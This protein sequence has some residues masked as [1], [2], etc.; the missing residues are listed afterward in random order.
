MEMDIK[1]ITQQLEELVTEREN[2]DKKIKLL[3]EEKENLENYDSYENEDEFIKK[4]V[5]KTAKNKIKKI[6]D[7]LEGIDKRLDEIFEKE[8]SLT[9]E[10]NLLKFQ[11]NNIMKSIS[12]VNS[13]IMVYNLKIRQFEELLD[14]A[15]RVGTNEE[16]IDLINKQYEDLIKE[17]DEKKKIL[18][19]FKYEGSIIFDSSK[20]KADEL[21]EITKVTNDDVEI[22]TIEENIVPIVDLKEQ[23]EEHSNEEVQM[24]MP[25]VNVIPTVVEEHNEKQL[26]ETNAGSVSDETVE[27]EETIKE[28]VSIVPVYSNE[29]HFAVVPSVEETNVDPEDLLSD[30]NKSSES[31]ESSENVV[32]NT[33]NKKHSVGEIMKAGYE[34]VKEKVIDVTQEAADKMK[35]RV[36]LIK[37]I[38]NWLKGVGKDVMVAGIVAITY[39][40]VSPYIGQ[41]VAPLVAGVST[42]GRG[43]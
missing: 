38:P 9:K 35:K 31:S 13:E 37:H 23:I 24:Q 29:E 28:E 5:R 14:K 10:K 4:T 22:Q 21:E 19:Q 3:N 17:R 11:A 20:K 15:K 33:S 41:F 42:F 8:I 39:L 6:N 26:D 32:E 36:K 30:L 12:S 2:L 25:E 7:K 43:K 16:I 18:D 34:A 27:D 1:R 40:L